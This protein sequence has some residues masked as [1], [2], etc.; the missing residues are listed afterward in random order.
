[1]SSAQ[2][3]S[4]SQKRK[5]Q[6]WSH[7]LTLPRQQRTLGG[8]ICIICAYCLIWKSSAIFI[9]RTNIGTPYSCAV[10]AVLKYKMVRQH[11]PTELPSQ[12]DGWQSEGGRGTPGVPKKGKFAEN[13]TT[14]GK[15][16]EKRGRPMPAHASATVPLACSIMRREHDSYCRC[17]T[18]QPQNW[19]DG[20]LTFRPMLEPICQSSGCSDERTA[21][22]EL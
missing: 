10:W 13:Q 6:S 20:A 3:F 18:Q 16:G 1:M 8:K 15:S 19:H 9:L 22:G 21:Q 12:A 17:Q 4:F 7:P 14:G 2:G 5:P 11:A